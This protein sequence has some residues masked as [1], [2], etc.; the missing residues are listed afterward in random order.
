[1]RQHFHHQSTPHHLRSCKSGL[2][3][4]LTRL[5]QFHANHTS[6]TQTEPDVP[7]ESC[8]SSSLDGFCGLTT[9]TITTWCYWSK[10]GDYSDMLHCQV[11]S[12]APKT[13]PGVGPYH[14]ARV[15]IFWAALGLSKRIECLHCLNTLHEYLH[16]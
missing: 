10:C 7:L 12:S 8:T 15:S 11:Q 1:M 16:L 13:R 2:A 6:N 9:Y 4:A 14:S 5:Q 3:K